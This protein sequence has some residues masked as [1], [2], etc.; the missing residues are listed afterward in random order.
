MNIY[1]YFNNKNY[2]IKVTNKTLEITPYT[3]QP[4]GIMWESESIYKFYSHISQNNYNILDIGAQTGLYALY[5][6]YLPNS[7][8]YAF[9]PFIETFNELNNNIELNEIKNIKTYNVAISDKS[10]KRNLQVCLSH[11]GLHTLGENVLRFDD[12]TSIPVNCNTIDEL[13]YN[14]G[15]PVH[16]IKI[17]TE[18]HEY[19]I[20]NGAIN[21]INTYKPLIQLEWNTTN[22]MQCNVDINI[23]KKFIEDIN[24]EIIDL[25]NEEMLI[26][27][28]K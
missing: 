28:K 10:E 22:M 11:N 12:K 20:L 2:P 9:E 6:K 19:Y 15:I 24:Y 5:A 25:T 4:N 7:T 26:Q 1:Y 23:F 13:F 21:T 14:K 8:F 18:G 16:Y 17:D 3:F 27:S